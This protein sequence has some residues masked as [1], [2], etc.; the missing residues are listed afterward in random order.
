MLRCAQWVGEFAVGFRS[1]PLPC[2]MPVAGEAIGSNPGSHPAHVVGTTASVS[3][4]PGDTRCV[5]YEWAN[6][7]L[8]H[9]HATHTYCTGPIL[10][11]WYHIGARV[12]CVC[13]VVYY[14]SVWKTQIF[15]RGNP[16]PPLGMYDAYLGSAH[17]SITQL[18][19]QTLE[20]SY[21]AQLN[22]PR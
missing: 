19:A 5:L 18:T 15:L 21:V 2:T 10:Y 16:A 22:P 14:A 4:H 1:A 13:V 8:I 17:L 12:V 3:R 11:K 6:Q 9:A 20:P 7:K